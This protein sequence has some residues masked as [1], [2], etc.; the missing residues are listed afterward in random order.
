MS[1]S[2]DRS[3]LPI[4]ATTFDGK[5][6]TIRK[7][8]KRYNIPSRL[9]TREQRVT[10][11]LA[12]PIH[13]LMEELSIS[14]ATGL[15]KQYV[16]HAPSR[17]AY[18]DPE[19][20]M[21]TLWVDRYRPT[22]Y[23]DLLG[24]DRVHREVMSWVKEWDYCVFG[25]K[26][27]KRARDEEN[28]DE[29][30]RP[31]ERL[32]LISGPPGLGKT[33][34]AHVIAKQAGY[35]VFEVNASDARSAQIVDDRIRPALES[36]SKVGSSK[37][38]LLVVDEIDGATGG[39][40]TSA[41]FIFKLVQLT[42]DK[43][44]KRSQSAKDNIPQPNRPLLRPIIC[45]CNDLYASSLSKL[46]PHARI[47]RFNRPND[48]RLVNRLREICEIEGLKAQ[49]RALTTLVGLAQGDLRG[50]LNTLQLIKA[51]NVEVTETIVRHAT[52]GM[53]EAEMSQT[54]VLNDLFSPMSTKRAKDLGLGEEDLA[55]YVNRLSREVEASGATDKIAV[56]CFEHYTTLRKHDANLNRFL[57]ASEWLSTY[58]L[59]SGEMRSEREWALLQY[60]PFMLV[61]LYPL[62]QERGNPKVERPKADWE[63]YTQ[64]RVNEE[65]YKTLAKCMRTAS[66]RH[67]GAYRHLASDETLQLEFAPMINRIISPPLRPVNK[68]VIKPDERALMSRLVDIMVAMELRF[69]QEK[70][71]DGQLMYR[72]DPPIDTFV[73]YDGK[74]AAD[75]AIS[76]YA[77]RH[78]VASEIDAQLIHKQADAVEKAKG[79][80][81]AFFG[82]REPIE[83]GT[84]GPAASGEGQLLSAEPAAR[85]VKRARQD[86]TVDI[87][88]KV[89]T[90][91]FGR[92]II[93][94][95]DGQK[96]KP[97]SR[98]GKAHV[99]TPG[100]AY[101]FN[102]GNSAAV[103]KLVKVSAFL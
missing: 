30:R 27:K 31:R 4:R 35:E 47:I 64:T 7:K 49:S 100:V 90:D 26:G 12:V 50:C 48:F 62:F 8:L 73:T 89:P 1:V 75:I 95:K 18:S 83:K 25:K 86:V 85:A 37:P 14:K 96:G 97:A 56:G 6:V 15:S 10:N 71:E 42:Q 82:R 17:E 72:L 65:V 81:H 29:Y 78:L 36:G 41:G 92:P 91:F 54:T 2:A 68:Q 3:V 38:T 63:S 101:R 44:K 74:R 53:K 55:R 51:K 13:R 34:L 46:R 58:D 99:R 39:S 69:I 93:V 19:A 87:E 66:T 59:F 33:T 20:P 98:V 23:L 24:D 9:N 61:P 11:L 40:D 79:K 70:S 76:R 84:N 21:G 102:E 43:P 77:I 103:R 94:R 32:L 57:K 60:L 22:C 80:T 28:L 16:R 52:V 5:T 88:E 45:I 67:G